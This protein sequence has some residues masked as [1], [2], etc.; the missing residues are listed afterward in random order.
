MYT[1]E[2]FYS[3]LLSLP[4]PEIDLPGYPASA[5][6]IN[7]LLLRAFTVDEVKISRRQMKVSTVAGPDEFP[8]G[9]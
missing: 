8:V 9:E 7:T 1:I 6:M 3:S 2:E 4:D 5:T